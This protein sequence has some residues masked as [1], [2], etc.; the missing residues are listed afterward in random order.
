MR[1]TALGDDEVR[2]GVHPRGLHDA[3]VVRVIILGRRKV[4]GGG[5]R[6]QDLGFFGGGAALRLEC[7]GFR[8]GGGGAA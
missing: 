1:D 8:F 2:G 6:V 4:G 7:L 5:F 3:Q